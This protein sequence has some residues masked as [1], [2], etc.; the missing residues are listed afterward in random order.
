MDQE[1][2]QSYMQGGILGSLVIGLMAVII[3][4]GN[5]GAVNWRT[6]WIVMFAF[7][8]PWAIYIY[9]AGNDML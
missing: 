8:L 9:L 4:F 3:T 5:E 2:M 1:T 7:A 6:V